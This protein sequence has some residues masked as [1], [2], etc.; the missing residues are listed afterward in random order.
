MSSR[1]MLAGTSALVLC[2]LIVFYAAGPGTSG[3]DVSYDDI[4]QKKELESIV[5]QRRGELEKARAEKARSRDAAAATETKQQIVAKP[6]GQ[7]QMGTM[8]IKAAVAYYNWPAL[9]NGNDASGVLLRA[10]HGA[11]ASKFNKLAERGTR[12][13]DITG[14]VQQACTG[15]TECTVE[16]V[17]ADLPEKGIPVQRRIKIAVDY[18]CG[19]EDIPFGYAPEMVKSMRLP[20]GCGAK[21]NSSV[22]T[23]CVGDVCAVR[24]E[25]GVDL[26]PIGF[27]IPSQHFRWSQSW[28]SKDFASQIP[29]NGGT[30]KHTE[31]A[32][33]RSAGTP[34][35]AYFHDYTHSY[36][37]VTRKKAGWDCLRHY[38]ILATGCVPFLVDIAALP[39]NTMAFFPRELVWEAMTLP[40]VTYEEDIRG[41]F[42]FPESFKIDH[43]IFNKTRY[44]ELAS[45][46]QA[47]A[48][49]HLTGGA[50]GKYIIDA[51]TASGGP[52]KIKKIL[53]VH[54]C[55]PDFMSDS[56]WSGLKEMELMGEL[57][58]V[59]DVVPPKEAATEGQWK[60]LHSEDACPGSRKIPST[61]ST[62]TLKKQEYGCMREGAH[63]THHGFPARYAMASGVI[64]GVLAGLAPMFQAHPSP[65]TGITAG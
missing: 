23:P 65:A 25:G 20:L 42:W 29:A 38:E 12:Y 15:K 35:E 63:Q 17:K 16:L 21:D 2:M 26:W 48:R 33:V 8:R 24:Y 51:V 50:M 34:D 13:V 62:T 4:K 44:F 9:V 41:S 60:R 56:I 39:A 45:Q 47:H 30:Y 52:K 31:S 32:G 27:S 10:K 49:R 37:C 14:K 28:K 36:Y 55:Y 53:Y 46:I 18:D 11:Y 6:V 1:T 7:A 19:A 54:H 5:R 59:A 64:A 22:Q 43:K 61:T 57:E 3:P 58:L 40:G